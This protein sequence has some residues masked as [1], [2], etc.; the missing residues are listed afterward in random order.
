MSGAAAF[1]DVDGT[2]LAGNIVRYYADL[3]TLHWAPA[4]RAAWMAWFA[5]RV[6]WYLLLD[7]RDRG[8][9]Q[10]A[11]YTNYRGFVAAELE[12]RARRYFEHRLRTR[13]F[14]GALARIAEHHR[15]GDR[16]VLVTGSL[17]PIVTPLAQYVAAH[18]VLCAE[19][20]VR[21]GICTGRLRHPPLAHTQKAQ[22]VRDC[23]A[24]LRLDD[25]ACWAY[26]DSR[27]DVPMLAQVGHA[28]VVNPGT[29]LARVAATRGWE[30]VRW[31]ASERAS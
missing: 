19:L 24:R 7:A 4:R 1:F 9:L 12:S 29:R 15:R 22:A 28:A 8:R 6:P 27:D 16:V 21:D 30:V 13:L 20:E 5:L 10:S 2:L 14:T 26:A 3:R 11:V 25:S 31:H 23:I 18:D 17:R